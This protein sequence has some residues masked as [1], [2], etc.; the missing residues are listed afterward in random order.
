M[1]EVLGWY[2]ASVACAAIG[3]VPACALFRDAP[4]RGVFFAR[5]LGLLLAG[6]C[7]W[8]PVSW[9][10]VPYSTGTVVL[11]VA[12][13][14]AAAIAALVGSSS[15]RA[16]VR[17][18]WRRLIVAEVVYLAA[19]VAVAAV[20]AQVPDA[21][22]A[23]KPMELML[24]TAVHGASDMP[25]PDAWFAGHDVSY[26][27][28]G[29]VMTDLLQPL[30]GV[31]PAVGLNLG[32]ASAVA[33]GV[34]ATIGLVDDILR[35]MRTVSSWLRTGGV[36]LAVAMVWCS[37][38]AVAAL[39]FIE[40]QLAAPG[41]PVERPWWIASFDVLPDAILPYPAFTIALGDLH[42]YVLGLPLLL[43][44]LGFIA[45]ELTAD[46]P[47]GGGW[48]RWR[49]RPVEFALLSLLFA[50]VAM[51]NIWDAVTCGVLWL[52]V[53]VVRSYARAGAAPPA[54]LDAPTGIA[55]VALVAIVIA[56]PMLSG[57]EAP[58][59]GSP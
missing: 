57:F 1:I 28:F 26:Y 31:S 44:V 9:T 58:C 35:R 37:A 10:P 48:R 20:R 11:G 59:P 3:V 7:V 8:L 45:Q 16:A 54:R 22:V 6:L 32:L 40:A 51:T 46:G 21:R 53:G 55:P 25:P 2:L 19:F 36:A 12:A 41:G 47:G 38:P 17:G 23:E 15:L 29:Y 30:A 50:D 13:V 42:P 49:R 18:S 56:F 43:A 34:V 33:M 4:S 52:A 5:P 24:L 27:Y 39:H 14:G